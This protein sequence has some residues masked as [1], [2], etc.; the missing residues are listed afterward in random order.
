MQALWEARQGRVPKQESLL[1]CASR[2]RQL[3]S[4]SSSS[5]AAAS[6][7]RGTQ[8]PEEEGGGKS[9]ALPLHRREG[10]KAEFQ[11]VPALAGARFKV[12]LAAP[13]YLRSS[14]GRPAKGETGERR[15]TWR[16]GH[17]SDPTD[18]PRA[19]FR[20]RLQTVEEDATRP[21]IGW[22]S[23]GSNASPS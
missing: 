4:Y 5:S 20:P 23:G 14:P 22:G 9:Y 15:P 11:R 17:F 8:P 12:Q 7:L 16:A 10:G 18:C 21:T 2:Q 6:Y 19:A 3:P 13:S 1:S